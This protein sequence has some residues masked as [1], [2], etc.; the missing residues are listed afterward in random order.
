MRD[1]DVVVYEGLED[2]RGILTAD[3]SMTYIVGLPDLARTG[4]S[5][6]SIPPARRRGSSS[7]SGRSRWSISGITV[8]TTAWAP[9]T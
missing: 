7:T 5:S 6:S 8:R 1:T 2:H 4:R 3:V 9:R